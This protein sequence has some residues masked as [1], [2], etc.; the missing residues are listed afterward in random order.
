MN[1]EA[2]NYFFLLQDFA[3]AAAAGFAVGIINQLLS[4]FVPPKGLLRGLKDVLSCFVFAVVLYS[5]VI[6]FTNYPDIRI[7]HILGG[8]AGFLCFSYN[9]STFFHKIFIKIFKR[10]KNNILCLGKKIKST[11]CAVRQKRR[12]KQKQSQNAAEQGHLQTKEVLV[13]NL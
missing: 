3:F 7:Y 5:Y 2:V 12:K 4:V 11:I 1:F 13:Y 8:C 9:F 10:I 6:S